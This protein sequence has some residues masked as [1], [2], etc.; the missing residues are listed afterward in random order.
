[1]GRSPSLDEIG[2][3][4]GPWTPEE[5]KRLADYIQ[6]NGHAS[7]RALPKLAGLNRCGKSCRLRWTNYLRPDIKRGKFSEEEEQIIIDLHAL[8]G[9]KW[10]AIAT[11]LP[12]RTDN[13]IKN[14]WNTHLRKK[15]LQMGIDPVTHRPRTDLS[16]LA[17]LPQLL[18]A[19]NFGNSVNL[20]DRSLRLQTDGTQ[21]AK[22][23]SLHN[24]L[25]VLSSTPPPT[26]EVLHLLGSQPLV[27]HH[28]I[29]ESL[30][31]MNSQLGGLGNGHI[32]LAPYPTEIQSNFQNLD[33]V[34][35]PT[36]E[37]DHPMG[38]SKVLN[39]DNQFG[40]TPIAG[41]SLPALVS[42]NDQMENKI[43]LAD[44]SNPSTTFEALGE[45][46]NDEA[47]DYYWRSDIINQAT[48]PSWPISR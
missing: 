13:E 20:W 15:L 26:M 34:Y 44:V 27:D 30:R 46:L 45:L 18:A 25:Q 7:W 42:V 16:I 12:G 40:V 38:S 35:Q 43:S 8:L 14:F 37:M 10:A 28:Q 17:N 4:K 32:N 47:D 48:T 31:I 5:D 22:I 39:G 9:N 24:I 6:R 36:H 11:H 23:Q 41:N 21:L 29:Y 1:M 19:P 33:H 3:K 2:L